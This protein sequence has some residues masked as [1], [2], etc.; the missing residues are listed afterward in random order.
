M[1]VKTLCLGV[2]SYGDASGY[3]IKKAF[4]DGYSHFMV[5]GF[6]SIYPALAELTE[7][8]LVTCTD[9]EQEK[10]PAKKV[11][12]LT[13]AGRAVLLER[14]HAAHPRHKVRSEFLTLLT[15]AH[16]LGPESAGEVLDRRLADIQA[17]LAHIDQCLESG[18][19]H[20]AGMRFAAG[21]ARAVHEAA[22]AYI[23][24]GRERLLD[25]L[26]DESDDESV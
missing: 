20:T 12:H 24:E 6:G 3:E 22:S 1:D 9:V 5:A 21:Y 14:L 25:E 8:G 10:R 19:A 23:R 11:Y 15:F 2:L 17:E 18:R 13:A 26:K 4:E 7:Q 16:L